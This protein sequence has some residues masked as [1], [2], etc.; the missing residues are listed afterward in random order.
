MQNG[1]YEII[2]SS[3]TRN[4][5]YAHNETHRAPYMGGVAIARRQELAHH[6]T[7]ISRI[8][9]RVMEVALKRQESHRQLTIFVTY[10]PRQGYTNK[11][12]EE[13]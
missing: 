7:R 5:R 8:Y 9:N 12:K 13:H 4:P 3:E 11:E 1:T 6:V 2:A 10:A